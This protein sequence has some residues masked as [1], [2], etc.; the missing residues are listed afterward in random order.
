[1]PQIAAKAVKIALPPPRD[2]M[3]RATFGVYRM[4][5]EMPHNTDLA[6]ASGRAFRR[7]EGRQNSRGH[8]PC[9]QE[10]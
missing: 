4:G 8:R 3:S 10:V 2:A 5:A 6:R 9:T 7:R 1:M